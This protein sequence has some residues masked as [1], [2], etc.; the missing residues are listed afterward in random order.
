MKNL[1]VLLLFVALSFSCAGKMDVNAVPIASVV[2]RDGPVG[3]YQKE[4]DASSSYD[5][6]G[7][8][9]KYKFSILENPSSRGFSVTVSE[10]KINYIFPEKG[11]YTIFLEVVD[12]ENGSHRTSIKYDLK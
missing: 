12:N 3:K 10:S 8:I 5:T 6:D 4:I 9:K 11:T 2:V 1:S 7:I